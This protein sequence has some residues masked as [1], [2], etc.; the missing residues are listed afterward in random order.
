MTNI[1]VFFGGKSSEH[2]IS[3]IT[4]LFAV[5]LLRSAGYCV[6]PV[7]IDVEG[8]LYYKQS[9]REVDEIVEKRGLVRVRVER[10][11][12]VTAG[13]K[14]KTVASIDC[15]LNAC[16]GGEGEDGTLSALL[17]WN[18]IPLAS[19]PMPVSAVFMD[20]SYARVV[21]KGLEIPVLPAF[22]VREEE[23]EK[24]ARAVFLKAKDLG[25]PLV[26]KPARL[27]SS[28]G[29]S[30][31]FC[32]EELSEAL[33]LAFRLDHSAVVEFYLKGKRDVNCAAYSCNGKTICS[34]CE[35]VFSSSHVLTFSEKYEGEKSSRFPAQLPQEVSEKI[36]AYTARMY[37]EFDCRGVVRADFLY[38]DGEVYFNEMNT[39]PGSFA[40]YLFGKTVSSARDFLK[41][42]VDDCMATKRAEKKVIYTGILR[43]T[44]FGA[45]GKLHV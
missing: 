15:A 8:E 10:G 44:A 4:G 45:K 1:A 27:G 16:H 33:S 6:H 21:A 40:Y 35:E 41:L 29:V 5:N 24:D 39:V 34:L 42:L 18:G 31:A 38:A 36:Q 9:L 30:V 28:I 7:L 12:L 20:K 14:R 3:V 19:P 13:K 37:E 22:R 25:Y 17:A 43:R 11:L 23:W 2:E 32:E 26:V